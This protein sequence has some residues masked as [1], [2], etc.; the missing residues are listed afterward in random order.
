MVRRRYSTRVLWV[1]ILDQVE[2]KW[3]SIRVWTTFLMDCRTLPTQGLLSQ[4]RTMTVSIVTK[5]T[6]R[7]MMMK[8]QVLRTLSLTESILQEYHPIQI[9]L[10]FH[11]K[12]LL[13]AAIMDSIQGHTM[14]KSEMRNSVN[15]PLFKLIKRQNN[16]QSFTKD[17]TWRVRQDIIKSVQ[18][19]K[20]IGMMM[21][22]KVVIVFLLTIQRVGRKVDMT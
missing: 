10:P 11:Q 22:V 16:D 12:L 17:L 4:D 2:G 7:I 13:M 21:T 1:R 3:H 5:K 18:M 20:R 15:T 6:M 9:L 14:L 8:I 19:K